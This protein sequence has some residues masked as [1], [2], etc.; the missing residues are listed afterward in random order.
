MIKIYP[1]LTNTI[2]QKYIYDLYDGEFPEEI[3][4]SKYLLTEIDLPFAKKLSPGDYYRSK[5]K[6]QEW[7]NIRS[8]IIEMYRKLIE[9]YNC[10]SIN[11][12]GFFSLS[13]ILLEYLFKYEI[14]RRNQSNTNLIK[15]IFYTNKCN[16]SNIVI[17]KPKSIINLFN[18]LK[19]LESL[20]SE[21]ESFVELRN[22]FVHCNIE[23]RKSSM[24]NFKKVIGLNSGYFI[25][26]NKKTL[27]KHVV[28]YIGRNK[29]PKEID[30]SDPENYFYGRDEA[31]L[32]I[33][34][35][36]EIFKKLYGDI[37]YLRCD[38]LF[39]QLNKG[40]LPVKLKYLYDR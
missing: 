8:E 36:F 6:L 26:K 19:E 17:N 32:S 1:D 9:Y 31:Y 24:A 7:Y 2:Y 14:S 15:D 23:K 38:N 27:V 16:L 34:L 30:E 29:K 39:M 5:S 12:A 21:I 4:T 22:S 28:G 25:I 40:K 33:S 3:I 10:H 37:N 11:L 20:R 35:I 13:G 18:Y